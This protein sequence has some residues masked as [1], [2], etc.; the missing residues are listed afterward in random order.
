VRIRNEIV[1]E[2]GLLEDSECMS[3]FDWC[4]L[5]WYHVVGSNDVAHFNAGVRV[6]RVRSWGGVRSYC[7]KYMAKLGDSD[8]LSEIPIGR[9]WGIFNREKI[10]WA[11][12]VDLDLDEET[13]V[14]LRRI[15]RRYLEHVRGR[16]VRAPYGITLYCNVEHLKCLWAPQPDVPF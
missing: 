13:G 5:A 10:P 7:S 8:F 14:R 4:S 1:T 15:M 9:S 3:F 6:E 16:R 2:K 11:K 12:I